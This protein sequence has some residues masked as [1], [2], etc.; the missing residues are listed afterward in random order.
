MY[1]LLEFAYS[2]LTS[3]REIA[4]RTNAGAKQIP[5]EE[6]LTITLSSFKVI[7]DDTLSSWEPFSFLLVRDGRTF[8]IF[9]LF[10]ATC[11][12]RDAP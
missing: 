8:S 7:S 4:R 11:N 5:S 12:R 10:A 1:R 2:L 3:G 9:G 6:T